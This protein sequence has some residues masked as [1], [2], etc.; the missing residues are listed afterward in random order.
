M[1]IERTKNA[2]R[3]LIYGV[4]LKVYQLLVP[5]FMRT[6]MIYQMGIEYAGLNNLFSSIFQ[7][8]NLA[9]LG[10]GAA[11]TCSMYKPIAEDN[12]TQICALLKLYKKCFNIIGA[13]V[14]GL[15]LLCVPFLNYLVKGGIP[16][17]LNLHVLYLMYL[18][19]TVLSYWLFSYKKSLLF[20]HQRNDINSKIL[21]LSQ[22]IQYVGQ[23]VILLV[24]KNYY[25]YLLIAII[26]Q[27]INNLVSA[28]IVNKLYPKYRPDGQ[29]EKEVI[30]DIKKKVQGLVTNKIGGVVLR[31]ADSIVISSF[32][33][34]TILA[35]YQNYYFILTA[36]IGVIAIIFEGCIAG[37][38]NSLIVENN[39]KNYYDLKTMTF[40][41]GWLVSICCCCFLVLYQPFIT[42]WVGKE[43][44]MEFPLVICMVVYF[45]IYEIE[46]LIGTFKDASGMWYADRYR[47]LI[48]ALVNLILNIILVQICGLYGVLL[49]T[50]ISLVC[51]SIPWLL[52]NVF[53]TIFEKNLIGKYIVY[54]LKFVVLT[55]LSA[56]ICVLISN[57]VVSNSIVS[58]L[59]K[60]LIA[61]IIPNCLILIFFSKTPE[62]KRTIGIIKKYIKK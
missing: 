6:I 56:I 4:I 53:T 50:V 14:L 39:E 44:L 21:I 1:K 36:V 49:S 24:L 62:F 34:L 22:T 42:A 9:E 46:T 15:G 8:L 28:I 3:N 18:A 57:Y 12:E 59:L 40:I 51:V 47:P 41:T 45:F 37:I 43:H 13:V 52:H 31:S 2:Q 60:A 32:L 5:F 16:D 20:A 11:L 30:Y 33:G 29:L 10:I 25:L 61:F 54:L 27:V 38:G 26:S 55:T 17:N 35:I 19:N 48:T 58:F 23:I 7:V